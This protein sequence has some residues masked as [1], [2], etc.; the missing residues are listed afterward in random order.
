VKINRGHLGGRATMILP[1]SKHCTFTASMRRSRSYSSSIYG[2][3]WTGRYKSLGC[4]TDR[5]HGKYV[6]HS[7][8]IPYTINLPPAQM[9]KNTKKFKHC[10]EI[11]NGCFLQEPRNLQWSLTYDF[12]KI[13]VF[14]T[15]L[16]YHMSKIKEKVVMYRRWAV[17]VRL[18]FL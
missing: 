1:L 9:T 10:P 3:F 11:K 14:I 12:R 6:V 15:Y 4:F 16:S 7:H 8:A 17:T 13:P 18:Q 5:R 2:G